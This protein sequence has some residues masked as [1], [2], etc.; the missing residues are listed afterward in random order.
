MSK[1][2]HQKSRHRNE[3]PKE[4][5]E[6]VLQIDRVTRVVK[7]GR[8][9]RFRATVVIGNKKGKVGLGVGKST[10][11]S[12]AIQKAIRKAKNGLFNVPMINETIPHDMKAKYKSAR[13]ML[14]PAAPG[15]GIIAGGA[16]RKVIELSGIK[17]I[18]SKAFGSTNKLNNA[19]ATFKA[20]ALMRRPKGLG[21]K[22]AE[23]EKEVAKEGA[24]PN[25]KQMDEKGH[26]EGHEKGH[27][28]S[29]AEK[30]VAKEGAQPNEKPINEK[31]HEETEKASEEK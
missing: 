19:Q 27:E 7:G 6:E 13:I 5:L 17:N 15:T 9:L 3:E 30:E 8:R 11:V 31:G 29:E 22:K 18:L 14:M 16:V 12:V 2:P 4:F 21:V 28:K 24:Q 1:N 10:E 20:L 25:E 23:P 26:G